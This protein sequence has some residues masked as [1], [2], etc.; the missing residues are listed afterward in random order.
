MPALQLSRFVFF[1]WNNFSPPK[2]VWTG[3]SSLFHIKNNLHPIPYDCTCIALPDSY[4]RRP[5]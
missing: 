3:C 4:L 1:L 5:R 2:L